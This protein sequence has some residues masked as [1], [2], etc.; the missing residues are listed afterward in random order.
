[1]V[2]RLVIIKADTKVRELLRILNGIT[3]KQCRDQLT[4]LYT[5]LEAKSKSAVVSKG[6]AVRNNSVGGLS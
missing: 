6:A 4:Q 2:V 5:L 1:M 3:L